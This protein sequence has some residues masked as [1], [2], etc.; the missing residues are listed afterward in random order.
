MQGELTIST[1]EL[2]E[3]KTANGLHLTV[4]QENCSL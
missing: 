3:M 2:S 4:S 1:E